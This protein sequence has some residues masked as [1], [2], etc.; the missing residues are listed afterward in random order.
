MQNFI[1][2]LESHN[3][4]KIIDTPLDIELE[5]PHLAYLEV[6]KKDSKALLFTQPISKT[7]IYLSHTNISSLDSKQQDNINTQN[8]TAIA[9]HA[10][11]Q[12]HTETHVYATQDLYNS[13][14]LDSKMTYTLTRS[15]ND[16]QFCITHFHIPVLMNVFGSHKRL[17]LIATHYNCKSVF[18]SLESIALCMKDLLN[19]SLPKGF[20]AKLKKLKELWLLRNIFPK[21]YKGAAPCQDKIFQGKE[22]DLFSLPI[23]KTWEEDGGRF[24]TMGQVY[25]Q[26]L[27]GKSRN[28]G[29]YRLQVKSKN[30]LLMHWQIHKDGAHF[31]HE[32]KQANKLMPV[33][34]AI[35]GDPLYIWCGQAPMP[36][37]MFELM[38]YGLIRGK[39]AELTKCI[40]NELSVPHDCDIVIEGYVDTNHFAPEGK[41]GDHTGFYT[42]IE[43]YPVMRVETIT[44]KNNPIYLATVVGKPPLEDKYMG[45]MTERLF[46]PLLQMSVHGLIDYAMPENGVFHNLILAKVKTDYPAQSLQ[47]MHAFFGLGQMSFVKHAI[48]LNPNAPSLHKDYKQ[49]TDYILKRIST[50]QLFIT[51][52]ICDVLD[53]ACESYAKSG[54]LG[55]DASGDEL[56]FHHQI[57]DSKT[58][59]TKMQNIAQEIVSL[60][61]YEHENPIIICGIQKNTKPILSYSRDFYDEL[62]EY[63]SFFIFVDSNNDLENYYMLIW[64][65]VNS[66][67]IARDLR[68]I[69]SCAFLDATAKSMIE[70]YEREWPKDTLC[71]KSILDSLAQKGLLNDIDD[72]F[73]QK[74]GIL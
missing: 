7:P 70:G 19:P 57:I 29:M 59:L 37:K 3:E 64:R 14:D 39:N 1:K 24:I 22:I 20:K 71:T 41:F 50:Q 16:T 9:P 15:S 21:T 56:S 26:S 5:I 47:M 18:S 73:L 67:D 28:V 40:S 36:P 58:L 30:E 25:T 53:H 8:L 60:H 48:F 61:I 12:H 55:I 51:Q 32:Y 23:L 66:I 34:I 27:D 45:Y 72:E 44:T 65:I 33:S 68:I 63:A 49:L 10:I 4:L 69:Q 2:F 31:F 74:F 46:L 52:G 17:A 11:T 38:L 54:K 62:H 6:K 42:P 35:G 43:S 13:N